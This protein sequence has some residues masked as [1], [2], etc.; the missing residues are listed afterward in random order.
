MSVELALLLA[1]PILGATVLAAVGARSWAPE[2][3]VGF[4]AATFVA[5]CALA[6]RVIDDQKL[7]LRAKQLRLDL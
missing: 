4:S 3:N 6:S 2:A 7:A 5:A 1:A